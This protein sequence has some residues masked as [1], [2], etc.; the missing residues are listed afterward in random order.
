[1]GGAARLKR[2]MVERVLARCAGEDEGDMATLLALLRRFA[3]EAAREEARLFCD[4]LVADGSM[5]PPPLLMA[6]TRLVA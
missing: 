5:L 6:E 2:R 3:V 4:D 1:Q